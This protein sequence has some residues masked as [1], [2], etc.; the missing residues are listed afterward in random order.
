MKRVVL[1]PL[2]VGMLLA[3]GL[4]IS[5]A[6]QPQPVESAKPCSLQ[7]LKGSYLYHCTGFQLVDGQQVHF[8]F[9]GR[10]QYNGDG[11]MSGVY[12]L[13]YNGEL[14]QHLSY[15]GTYTV[16]PDCTGAFTTTDENGAVIHADLYFGRDGEEV[17]FVL[18][19]PGVVDAGVER[20]VRH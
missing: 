16:N 3:I 15:T 7:T 6:G 10:D 14:S 1:G 5:G 19:D 11:T 4:F 18:T 13:S 9:A 8:A 12:S 2:G 20:R 17:S